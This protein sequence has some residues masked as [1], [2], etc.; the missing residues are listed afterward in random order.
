ML[1]QRRGRA[2]CRRVSTT[3]LFSR[4]DFMIADTLSYMKRIVRI[5]LHGPLS[6]RRHCVTFCS[7]AIQ[8]KNS[9]FANKR[10][11]YEHHTFWR[12]NCG[13][14]SASF[15]ARLLWLISN[16]N[17]VF[18]FPLNVVHILV[19]IMKFSNKKCKA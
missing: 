2:L 18:P 5:C 11:F 14:I 3:M 12:E 6:R 4:P 1:K 16:P 9:I 10:N 8:P 13:I 19:H 17:E 15:I 7:D